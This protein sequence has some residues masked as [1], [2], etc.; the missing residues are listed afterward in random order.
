MLG[1]SVSIEPRVVEDDEW[2]H[3]EVRQ[4][5]WVML[6]RK[7]DLIAKTNLQDLEFEMQRI[8]HLRGDID[9]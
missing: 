5:L 7:G 4:D 3:V 1:E 2:L 6:R 8:E 9:A